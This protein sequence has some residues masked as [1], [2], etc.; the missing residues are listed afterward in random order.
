VYVGWLRIALLPEGSALFG[1]GRGG[2]R[3]SRV[4]G[5]EKR[6]IKSRR[7]GKYAAKGLS[8]DAGDKMARRLLKD[9]ISSPSTP[10]SR[11][12]LPIFVFISIFIPVAA[13]RFAG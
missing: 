3:M 2:G 5:M 4:L 7:A 9:F 6:L 12:L 10:S 1:I 11:R 13:V 8:S